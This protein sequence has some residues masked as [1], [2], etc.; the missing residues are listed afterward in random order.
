MLHH[1]FKKKQN[2][3]VLTYDFYEKLKTQVDKTDHLL[4]I[5][6]FSDDSRSTKR[7]RWL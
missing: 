3:D 1:L 6:N 2:K 4:F 7:A 5:L